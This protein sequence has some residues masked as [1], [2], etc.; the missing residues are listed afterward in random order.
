M[1]FEIPEPCREDWDAMERRPGGRFCQKCRHDVIDLS[2]MTKRQAKKTLATVKGSYV[3]VQLATTD[4]EATFRPEASRIARWAG[5]L[6]IAAALSAGCTQSD[7]NAL[8]VEPPCTVQPM[9]PLDTTEVS[10]MPVGEPTEVLVPQG[11]PQTP[12]QE[13]LAMTAEKQRPV[14]QPMMIRGRMPMHDNGF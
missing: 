11:G 5:G 4:G 10:T 2:R 6:A 14:P 8:A 9:D 1:K 13:Q 12:T 7:D 3:C